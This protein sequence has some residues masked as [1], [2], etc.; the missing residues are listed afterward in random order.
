MGK[1]AAGKSTEVVAAAE[2]ELEDIE[3]EAAMIAEE[4]TTGTVPQAEVAA[5]AGGLLNQI[6]ALK[7]IMRGI[8]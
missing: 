2:R 5:E 8:Q 3:R 1:I 4:E 6:N 7:A